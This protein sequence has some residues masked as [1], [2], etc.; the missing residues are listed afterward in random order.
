[1]IK[2]FYKTIIINRAVPRSGKTTITRHI[3]QSLQ[4]VG[5]QVVN[6]STDDFFMNDGRYCF[7]IK[8]LN[9]YHQRNLKN[10]VKDLKKGTDIVI[11]DNTNLQ[12]WQTEPYTKNAR[13]YGYKIIFLNLTPRE[14]HKHV[15]AQLVTPEK[16]DAHGVP[17]ERLA[18]FI[19]DFNTYNSLLDKKSP[20]NRKRHFHYRWDDTTLSPIAVGTA[21]HFD[22]DEVITIEPHEY[23][24]AKVNI[25]PRFL[26]SITFQQKKSIQS[27]KTHIL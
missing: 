14:L 9:E 27:G 12:P 8:K 11:C 23:H 25:G 1:M 6:H 2:H 18:E 4:S 5:L 7:D 16:P 24:Q 20:I 22:L 15:Q 21:Q 19:K 17:E 3:T 13:K 26:N 10:F